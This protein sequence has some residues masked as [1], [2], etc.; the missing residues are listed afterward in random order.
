ME[1]IETG[2]DIGRTRSENVWR[3]LVKPPAKKTSCSLAGSKGCS[4]SESVVRETALNTCMY[5]YI[6]KHP[7]TGHQLR[8][9]GAQ[10]PSKGDLLE[11][12]G[13]YI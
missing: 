9:G 13:I 5:V 4:S 12:A 11:D 1:V 8:P 2:V 7:P 3:L 10:E 6:Y